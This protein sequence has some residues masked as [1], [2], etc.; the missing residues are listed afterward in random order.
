MLPVS[1]VVPE[2]AVTPL[3]VLV[4]PPVVAVD[5]VEEV[6]PVLAQ[7]PVRPVDPVSDVMP[8]V[9]VALQPADESGLP[10]VSDGVPVSQVAELPVVPVELQLP[11]PVSPQ[12]SPELLHDPLPPVDPVVPLDPVELV[13]PELP[14]S[15][16]VVTGVVP[17]ASV[18]NVCTADQA[19]SNRVP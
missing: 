10:K 4:L 16:Q 12:P 6:D 2:S 5:P 1:P 8:L 19:L 3:E 13:S 17:C 14:L 15:A 18:V 9:F 11:C 7:V